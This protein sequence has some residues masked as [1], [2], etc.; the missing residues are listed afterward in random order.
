MTKAAAA[1]L[2]G[3]IVRHWAPDGLEDSFRLAVS[4]ERLGQSPWRRAKLE[5]SV[6]DHARP[7]GCG[8]EDMVGHADTVSGR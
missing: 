6:A 5:G 7:D 3:T 4:R 8:S 2:A 1:Q